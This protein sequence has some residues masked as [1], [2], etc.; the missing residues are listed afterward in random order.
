MVLTVTIN[1]LL[2]R[3]LF[4]K[5]VANGAVNRTENEIYYAGGKGINVS[6]QLNKLGIDNIAL[7]FMGGASGKKLRSVLS[8]EGINFTAVQTSNE[9]RSGTIAI[10][11]SDNSLTTFIGPSTK[12]SEKEADEFKSKLEKMINNASLVVFAGSSCCEATD[13]IFPFG[14]EV[15]GKLDKPCI[16]DT[17]GSHLQACINA[18]PT[19]LH[20]NAAE[21]A[22]SLGKELNS[23]ADYLSLLSELYGKGIKLA[24]VTN[25]KLPAYSSKFD[26]HYKI[27]SPRVN[28]IDPTGSGDAFTAGLVYGLEH[29]LVYEEFAALAAALGSANAAMRETCEVEKQ[30]ADELTNQV[31]ITPIGKKMKVIDDSPTI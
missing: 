22:K 2:E 18:A 31:K 16:V 9:T 12:I 8:G 20:N 28:E 17:Y 25:G 27:E 19:A 30:A 14:I 6:R 24:F 4:Y 1:P 5:S 26:F 11:E 21:T 23:D 3:R 10:D 29:A 7:T 13:T 15:C